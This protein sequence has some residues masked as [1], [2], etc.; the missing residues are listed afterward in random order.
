MFGFAH[1]RLSACSERLGMTRSK[2]KSATGSSATAGIGRA[3]S[4]Q[5]S[6]LGKA[7]AA[8]RFA[9]CGMAASGIRSR[10]SRNSTMRAASR[11]RFSA[12]RSSSNPPA[13]IALSGFL[14]EHIALAAVATVDPTPAFSEVPV[15]QVP[16]QPTQCN[17][18]KLHSVQAGPIHARARHRVARAAVVLLLLLGL[19]ACSATRLAYQNLDWLTFE[20]MDDRFDIRSDQEGWVKASLSNLHS[21]HRV[22]QLPAYRRTLD[23]LAVRFADGLDAED[24]AWLDEEVEQHRR[25]LVD[26]VVPELARF[27]ADLDDEQLERFTAASQESIDEAAEQLEWSPRK[28]QE[29]RF[30][31]F[32]DRIEPWTGDLSTEQLRLLERDVAALSDIRRE[33]IEQRRERLRVFTGLLS[34][35]PGQQAIE[36]ALYA[37]WSD[38]DA[39]YP[40][41]Y[42][43]QRSLLK[44]QMFGFLI[45]LD[46]E[47]T[48]QQRTHVSDRLEAY[49]STIDIV[50]ASR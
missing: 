35:Q 7:T 6:G 45:R 32:V 9:A 19:V 27:L 8:T 22:T 39:S 25:S 23:E 43:V 28:R 11:G 13:L 17:A 44:Q 16:Q 30:E 26:L 12:H 15:A 36:A 5:R 37:W 18:M 49:V 40:P 2:G 10:I 24:L 46:A 4:I 47:L 3:S 29:Y 31:A 38:L 1:A 42:V 33:W 21:W 41:D 20:A 34:T 48:P 14:Q 50:V